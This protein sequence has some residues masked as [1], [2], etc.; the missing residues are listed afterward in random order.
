MILP[1]YFSYMK[2]FLKP[3]FSSK[4]ELNKLIKDE[5]IIH[6]YFGNFE[7][8]VFY[9]SPRGEIEP[10]LYFSYYGEELKWRDFGVS[11]NPKNA[12]E[13]FMFIRELE[14]LKIEFKE[15]LNIIYDEITSNKRTDFKPKIN[16]KIKNKT[17]LKYRKIFYRWEINYWKQY[18]ITKEILLNY[19]VYPCEIWCNNILWHKSSKE[20]PLFAYIFDKEKEI[21]KAYRPSA[22]LLKR[23]NSQRTQKF[24]SNNV[25]HHVQGWEKLPATGEMCTIT[26]SYKDVIVLSLLNIPAI[27]PHSESTFIS[28]E[29]LKE[30]KQRFK[31]IYVNYD[32]DSTGVNN[33]LVFTKKYNLPYWNI[34]KSYTDCKDPSDVVKNYSLKELD[35][36][37]KNKLSRDGIL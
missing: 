3:F 15:A 18:Q 13:Y 23:G 14:G 4:N 29:Q 19:N 36:I 31:H 24:F 8:E 17:A 34:P 27:A 22:P 28:D 16:A 21:W 1:F 9:N 12:V 20:D 37:I 30:L 6:Y 7:T 10:S 5:E 32:N 2:Y 25:T 11:V 26:K 35:L 33:S